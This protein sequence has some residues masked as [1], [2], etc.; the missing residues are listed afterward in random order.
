M[1]MI[2]TKLKLQPGAITNHNESVNCFILP[3]NSQVFREQKLIQ[4]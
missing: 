2:L 4:I 3:V 1:I